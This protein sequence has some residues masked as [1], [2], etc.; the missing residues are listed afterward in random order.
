MTIEDAL[1]TLIGAGFKVSATAELVHDG[2][3][4]RITLSQ[5]H[6][7]LVRFSRVVE[8]VHTHMEYESHHVV[9]GVQVPF[10]TKS[11][12]DYATALLGDPATWA[13]TR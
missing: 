6:H 1:A 9:G 8:G 10:D 11:A 2:T 5:T 4:V 13:V 12:V 3:E 7:P